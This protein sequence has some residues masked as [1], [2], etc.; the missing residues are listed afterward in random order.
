MRRRLRVEFAK[1][2]HNVRKREES[3]RMSAAP[4]TTLFVAG[5]DPRT[6]RTRDV[7][8]AFEPYGRLKV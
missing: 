6:I 4:N 7:E 5:F 2:D 8:R 1:N 3:R